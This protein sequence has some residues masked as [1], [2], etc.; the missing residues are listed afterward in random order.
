MNGTTMSPNQLFTQSKKARYST[1]TTANFAHCTFI[2]SFCFSL[3][4]II[5]LANE[6]SLFFFIKQSSFFSYFFRT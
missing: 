1:M 6:D 3:S 5:S 4:I 2:F